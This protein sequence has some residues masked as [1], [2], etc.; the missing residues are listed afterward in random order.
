MHLSSLDYA[1]H[2]QFAQLLDIVLGHLL[3]FFCSG[4]LL[5]CDMIF[6]GNRGHGINNLLGKATFLNLTK[7][8]SRIVFLG[9]GDRSQKKLLVEIMKQDED[10]NKYGS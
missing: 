8:P 9:K 1:F 6:L 10:F 2:Y 5:Q 3:K 4:T 7:I